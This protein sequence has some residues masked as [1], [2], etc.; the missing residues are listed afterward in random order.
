MPSCVKESSSSSSYRRRRRGE[1]VSSEQWGLCLCARKRTAR[2]K[3]ETNTQES[4]GSPTMNNEIKTKS[5]WIAH[6]MRR[7][8]CKRPTQAIETEKEKKNN[9]HSYRFTYAHTHTHTAHAFNNR[10]Y[11]VIVSIFDVPQPTSSSV[12]LYVTQSN[13]SKWNEHF[14]VDTTFFFIHVRSIYTLCSIIHLLWPVKR[15]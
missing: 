1:Y 12:R 11:V 3:T 7:Y 9:I 14:I 15:C 6:S 10:L 5:L 2:I 13:V 4:I 8:V